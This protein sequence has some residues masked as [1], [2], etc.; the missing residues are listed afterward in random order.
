MKEKDTTIGQA[1]IR[2]ARHPGGAQDVGAGPAAHVRHV[3]GHGAG[4]HSGA[5]LRPAPEHPDHLVLCRLWHP[6]FP[7]VHE[8]G[9]SGLPGII[10]CL[11]GRVFRHGEFRHRQVR[12]HGPRREAPVR[13]RRHCGGGAALCDPGPGGQGGGSPSGDALFAPGGHRPHHHSHRAEPGPLGGFQCLHL[14]VAGAGLHGDHCGCQH[15]GP[16]AW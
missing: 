15:L 9:D 16:V 10:L 3:W 6:V 7:S 11:S 1:P 12:C 4:S 8:A 13:L 2:D 14:L 5:E